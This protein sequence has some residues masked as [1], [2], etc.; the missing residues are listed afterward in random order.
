[1][2][3]HV[4][5]Q[6]KSPRYCLFMLFI[7]TPNPHLPPQGE[8]GEEGGGDEYSQLKHARDPHAVPNPEDPNYSHFKEVWWRTLFHV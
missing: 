8:H 5:V 3:I 4:A 7:S 6:T 1:M 2:Y